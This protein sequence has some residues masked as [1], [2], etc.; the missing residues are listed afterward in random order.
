MGL[1]GDYECLLSVGLIQRS[2][3]AVAV[4]LRSHVPPV[5]TVRLLFF[6]PAVKP[7]AVVNQWHYA[8]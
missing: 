8:V 6:S 3:N 7:V 2:N 1:R 5:M 4:F